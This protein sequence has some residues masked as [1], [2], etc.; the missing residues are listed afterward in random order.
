ML[1]EKSLKRDLDRVKKVQRRH[2]VGQH[3]EHCKM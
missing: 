1:S 2:L 3:K